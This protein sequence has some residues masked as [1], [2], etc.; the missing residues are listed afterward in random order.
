MYLGI[1][2][3]T[4]SVKA[5]LVNE[6][7]VI[8][9]IAQQPYPILRPHPNYAE[10]NPEDWWKATVWAV[11]EAT[12][13]AGNQIRVIGI[14]GQ[15]H[16]LV[17]L[18]KNKELLRPAIIWMDQRSTAECEIQKRE[19]WLQLAHNQ[20]VPG[21]MAASLLWMKVHE[22]K[23]FDR[24]DMVLT[25]KDWLRWK[26]TGVLCTEV[27]DASGTLMM[28]IPKRQWSLELVE[29]YG[30][31]P[32][33]L[34]HVMES[35]QMIEE[36]TT[37]ASHEL[38]LSSMP[39]VVA[40]A[41]D[42]AAMLV[43]CGVLEP[44][45]AVLTIGTGGQLSVVTDVPQ[46]DGRLNTFCHA[47]PQRW[48]SMGAI[49]AA[50]YALAWW[51]N[52][53]N[54]HLNAVL[55]AAE[56]VPAGAEGIIFR[57]YL[58]GERTPHLNPTLTASFEGLTGRH[59]KGHL[60]R[61]VLEGVAFAMR[62]CQKTLLEAGASPNRII[63]GGGGGQGVLWRQIMASVLQM[64]LHSVENPEQTA[65]GAAMLAAAGDGRALADLNWVQMGEVTPP[66]E[67]WVEHYEKQYLRFTHQH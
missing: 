21:F 57:P 47:V 36:A 3:G 22:P 33:I 66:V 9:R 25:P 45:Q 29:L 55:R 62:D 61:A 37:D 10:Q 51:K 50:G 43:G 8:V 5:L 20:L 35:E 65:F 46:P 39:R 52:V 7:G 2:L 59:T 67:G 1:D 12:R 16:G 58:N 60:T 15:M 4:Q 13:H 42:Q 38:G 56:K 48:Y 40:G 17:T 49:L 19:N 30:F 41:A 34:P 63:M 26:L 31:P 18:D 28:D 54:G 24:I 11:Q 27:S 53:I 64:P 44:G 32:G 23:L 6:Q 14:A